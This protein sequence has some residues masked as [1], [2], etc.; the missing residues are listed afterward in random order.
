MKAMP[1]KIDDNAAGFTLIE[2]MV[3]AGLFAVAMVVLMGS[4]M[5]IM[6]HS[7]IADMRVAAI[8]LNHSTLDFMRGMNWDELKDF[9]HPTIDPDTG[10]A[11]VDGLGDVTVNAWAII[12]DPGNAPIR[13][14][15]GSSEAIATDD[16]DIPNPVELQIEVEVNSGLI[17]GADYSFRTSIMHGYN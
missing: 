8:N 17:S 3:V 2:V 10:I 12:P 1:K 14:L 11:Y 4:L 16:E 13:L 7:Q 15:L 6:R 5:T 9:V